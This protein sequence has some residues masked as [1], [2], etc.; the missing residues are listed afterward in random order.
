M[1]EAKKIWINEK[2]ESIDSLLISN[3]EYMLR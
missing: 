2:Y 1:K 3:K